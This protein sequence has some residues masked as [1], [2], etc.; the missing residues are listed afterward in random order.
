MV[1]TVLV[2]PAVVFGELAG[3]AE[4]PEFV[5]AAQWMLLAAAVVG[6]AAVLVLALDWTGVISRKSPA[7]SLST[8]IGY[9]SPLAAYRRRY[10]LL[11]GTAYLATMLTIPHM[12]ADSSGLY[13][14]VFLATIGAVCGGFAV[15]AHMLI[16]LHDRRVAWVLENPLVW[17]ARNRPAA[18]GEPSSVVPVGK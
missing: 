16:S 3:I 1:A 6:S 2:M 10:Y 5:A 9:R 18:V 14:V 8:P 4:I 15:S 11:A 13:P 12:P 17:S 7:R